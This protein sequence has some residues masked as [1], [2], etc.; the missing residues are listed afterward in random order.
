M[1]T[2]ILAILVL[3]PASQAGDYLVHRNRVPGRYVVVL[4]KGYSVEEIAPYVLGKYGGLAPKS[5]YFNQLKL[6]NAI[7]GFGWQFESPEE[8][9]RA[10]E[11]LA[12]EKF[13]SYVEMK[14][15]SRRHDTMRA[16][17]FSPSSLY[18]VTSLNRAD[19]LSF[20]SDNRTSF[21]HTGLGVTVYVLDDAADDTHSQFLRLYGE[22]GGSRAT[23]WRDAT[24]PVG[25]PPV[26]ATN[27]NSHGTAMAA[28]AAGLSFGVAR[29]ALVRVIDVDNAGMIGGGFDVDFLERGINYILAEY[30][31]TTG[32]LV[33]NAK[34]LL[35]DCGSLEANQ[36]VGDE[37]RAALKA[38]EGVTQSRVA[39][40]CGS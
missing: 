37:T 24:V 17:A 6:S 26:F 28:C 32:P 29:R 31:A 10:A 8:G 35:G 2:V 38:G 11:H 3:A 18:P 36:M 12:K 9:D 15:T 4:K 22:A 20:K 23:N 13:I 7:E 5:S 33:V 40:D 19:A 25:N 30:N 1:R 27:G 16:A 39:L 34:Q 14:V 21:T